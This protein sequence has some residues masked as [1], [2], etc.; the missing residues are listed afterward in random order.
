MN[1]LHLLPQKEDLKKRREAH[2]RCLLL[3]YIELELALGHL[4]HAYEL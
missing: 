4:I 1:I 2:V 3:L